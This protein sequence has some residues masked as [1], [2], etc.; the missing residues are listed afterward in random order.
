MKLIVGLGNP[1]KKYAKT[2]HN[3]GFMAVDALYQALATSQPSA[4]EMSKNFNAA[5]SGCTV[6]GKKIILAKPATFMNDSGAAVSAIAHFYKISPR[7]VIVIHDDKDIALGDVKVQAHRGAAGHRGVESVI[8]RL[9][10]EDFTRIRI[11]VKPDQ[12]KKMADT[13]KFVLSNFGFF[14][15][16]KLAQAIHSAVR[17][18]ERLLLLSV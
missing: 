6:G 14:E 7:D 1:G 15:K 11:G 2:R 10:T 12:E 4:W 9:G 13:A 8:L 3:A 18:A 5:L 16:K 17:E